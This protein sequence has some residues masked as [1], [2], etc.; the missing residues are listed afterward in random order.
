MS[1]TNDQ[2]QSPPS[3]SQLEAPASPTAAQQAQA[4]AQATAHAYASN[5]LQVLQAASDAA[6]AAALQNVQQ[7][8]SSAVA[9]AD[10]E[11]QDQQAVDQ[12]LSMTSGSDHHQQVQQQQQQQQPQTPS[13]THPPQLQQT[14]QT[15]TTTAPG[16]SP[17]PIAADASLG[18]VPQGAVPGFPGFAPMPPLP[19][20]MPALPRDPTVN[21]KLTRLRRACDMCSQRKVKCDE[22]GPPCRPC[23]EL[24]VDCTFNRELKRR[25]PPNKHAEAARAA[26]RQRLEPGNTVP[27]YGP[28]NPTPSPHNAAQALVSIAEGPARLDAEAI[29]PMPILELLVDDFFT[30]IHPLAPFPHEPT[31]R[32]SFANREDRTNPE[33]LGLLASMIG[34]LVASFPRSARQH[35]KTQHSTHLF[36]RAI[37]MIEKCRDIALDTRGARWAV[38][39]P[40]TLDDAATSYFLGLAAGYTFEVNRFRYFTSECL[41]LIRELGFHRP[42]HPGELP[43]FGNDNCSPDP[44]PFHHIKDQIGKRIFWCLLLG[45]RSFSQ[46][47]ASH[48]DLV[49]APSTPGLPYPAL[50]E[51]VDDLYIMANEIV[52]PSEDTVTL[53]TGYRFAIEIYTTMN[54]IVSVEL[55]YGMNTLP[56]SDQRPILRDALVAAK[57]IIDRLPTELQLSAS[58]DQSSGFGALDDADLQYVPPAYPNSQPPNDVRNV[59]KNQPQRRR[60]LQYEIQKANIYISQLATRSFY[61]E[62]Y[63]NLRDVHLADPNKETQNSESAEE[64]AA[65]EAEDSAVFELM[66]AERELIVQNLLHVLGSISQRNLEPNGGSLINKIRQVASTL[67][68]DAPERKGPVAMNSEEALMRLIDVLLKLEGTGPSGSNMAGENMTPQDE[69]EEMRN[70]AHLRDYQQRFAAHGGFAGNL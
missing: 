39:Q 62:L 16:P 61:V 54:A 60:Q 10:G 42:K 12:Q 52:F 41:A 14:P 18:T 55:V 65:K 27:A 29:A 8:L 31:F 32:H 25:G 24:N 49:I 50:P 34:A 15:V 21:P 66:T 46:L 26:R 63:F 37:V 6:A 59:I 57:E 2:P 20:S 13:Q 35:L 33:F 70:W 67:L 68:N 40:K 23:R 36:P 11:Q 7:H 19:G 3:P 44:L 45:V 69:E 4:Q 47:G 28:A 38:K 30:Y 17:S 58:H 22:A 5:G 64:K 51:N 56:W 9:V 1:S 53:L 43:T 48:A